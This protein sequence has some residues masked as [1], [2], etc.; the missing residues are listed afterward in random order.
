MNRADEEYAKLVNRIIEWGEDRDD[1]TG[2]GTRSIFGYQY[3]VNVNEFP[4]LTTKFVNFY[5][6]K[7]EL[8]WFLR[9]ETTTESLSKHTSIWEPWADEFD[10]VGPI[11]GKQWRDWERSRGK[12]I[13]QISEALHLIKMDPTSRRIIVSAWNVADIPKM[14]LPPCH[15][16]FQFYVRRG[17]YLDMQLYQRSADVALGVPF[18]LASYALLLRMF[19]NECGLKAGVF[20]HTFGDVHIYQNHIEQMKVQLQE[21]HRRAPVL[22]LAR[23]PVLDMTADDIEIANY[24]HGPRVHYKV[25]V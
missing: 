7:H 14:S 9:G 13:D 1:R 23:K 24:A 25:A 19:A 18:N 8:L 4:L 16:M 21:P 2:V 17:A 11:Y 12:N 6:I 10:Y 15:M 22:L 3:K 20:T 5:A